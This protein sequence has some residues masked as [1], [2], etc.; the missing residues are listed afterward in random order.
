MEEIDGDMAFHP[1]E[2][3]VISC[4]TVTFDLDLG[5]VLILWSNKHRIY[6]LPKGRRNLDE[7]LLAAALRETYEEAGV[8]VKPLQLNVATRATPPS[9]PAGHQRNPEITD[10]QL[11][12][13][14]V[15]ACTYSDPQTVVPASKT[16]YFF[17][18]TADS[19]VTPRT[20]TQ[21]AWENY[22]SCWV[23]ISE[24]ARKLRFKAEVAAV[25]KALDDVKKTG[26]TIGGPA[27]VMVP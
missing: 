24:V 12:Y 27:E 7:P 23:P 15:G 14:F 16:V 25:M 6:Q 1:A 9:D 11:S 19:T 10:G 4:G 13:E 3:L 21:E 22:V 17:A 18:A 26:L 2:T 8:R 20:G 5:K